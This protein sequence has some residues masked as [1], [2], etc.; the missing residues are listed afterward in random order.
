MSLRGYLFLKLK[1]AKSWVTLIPKK[2]RIRTLM[3]SQHVTES[4]SLH[5]CARQYFCHI[6]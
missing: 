1:T 2:S 5:K 3:D 4:E 6:S